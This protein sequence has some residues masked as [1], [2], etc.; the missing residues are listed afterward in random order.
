M[1][2][3]DTDDYATNHMG[4]NARI[5]NNGK[6]ESKIHSEYMILN[7]GEI[8]VSNISTEYIREY[9]GNLS[10]ANIQQ[11]SNKS[12]KSSALHFKKHCRVTDAIVELVDIFPT[13]ADLAGIPI[14]ICQI[15]DANDDQSRLKDILTQKKTSDPCGE[16]IT[17][18]P[19]IKSTLE[20]Q[21]RHTFYCIVNY[22][23]ILHKTKILHS[24]IMSCVN[25]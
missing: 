14:P 8:N 24:Y 25:F 4:Y 21:V 9:K 2:T 1:I 11:E 18:L 10:G 16:G 13:I 17:L 12:I 19:L 20:C 15:N 23:N 3:F 6:M 22:T 5:T 7:A